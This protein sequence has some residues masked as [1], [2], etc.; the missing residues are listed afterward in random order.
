MPLVWDDNNERTN[1]KPEIYAF[2][3][4]NCKSYYAETLI[5]FSY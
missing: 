2:D 3:L 5:V 4:A 1:P